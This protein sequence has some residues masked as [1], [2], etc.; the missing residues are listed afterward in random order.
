MFESR[1]VSPVRDVQLFP[2]VFP[3]SHGSFPDGLIVPDRSSVLRLGDV[4]LL[5][6]SLNGEREARQLRS[7][8]PLL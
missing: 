2:A 5:Q 3:C 6:K 8:S 7:E 1:N 4:S